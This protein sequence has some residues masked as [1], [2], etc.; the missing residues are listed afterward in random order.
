MIQNFRDKLQGILAMALVCLISIPFVLF[1]VEN[2]FT[3]GGVS[4]GEAAKVNDQ[5]I[6]E[7]ELSRAIS[8][9]KNQLLQ[10]TNGQ[11]PEQFLS[12]E[13]LR[14]PVLEQLIQEALE[15]E[16]AQAS[17]ILIADAAIDKI[18]LEQQAFQQDG[19]FSSQLFR[20]TLA[21]VGYTPSSYRQALQK[22]LS[23]N[24]LRQG[25]LLSGFATATKVE[26]QLLRKAQSRSF[27]FMSIAAKQVEP[28]INLAAGAARQHYD[29]NTAQ[30]MGP[31]RVK[32]EYI[33]LDG[34]KLAS[35]EDIAEA[36]VFDA[37]QQ[38]AGAFQGA[39]RRRIAHILVE[40]SDTGVDQSKVE[41][42]KQ[43]LAS[44][45][46]FAELAQELSDDIVTAEDGGELGFTDGKV[47]DVALESVVAGL[48]VD[49]VSAPL[50]TD[51]GIHFIKLL[52]IDAPKVPSFESKKSEIGTNLLQAKIRKRYNEIY[53][54]LE[55][56]AY[57]AD[58][59]HGLAEQLG[60]EARTSDWVS[61]AGGTGILADASVLER[62]FSDEVLKDR[63]SS[64]VIELPDNRAAVVRVV[65]FEAAK[66]KPFAVVEAQITA[67]LRKQQGAKLLQAKA[68]SLKAKL[69]VGGDVE[70][71]AKA[72]GVDWQVAIDARRNDS[73]VDS[74]TLQQA[75]KLAKPAADKPEFK[76]AAKPNGDYV[77]IQLNRVT[78][79]VAADLLDSQKVTAS[80]SL[81]MQAA[82][83]Q[84]QSYQAQLKVAAEISR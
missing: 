39:E 45:G 22:E 60:I 34:A 26:Q 17:N 10:Q 56:L 67:T 33:D 71:V 75:F 58:D 57:N 4:Q 63:N 53:S 5:V 50:T 47:F 16:E 64:G 51:E 69:Q 55:D 74:F 9:R 23:V 35:P 24:Q 84:F 27:Y 72:G 40:K 37:Y 21:Q 13:R 52:E 1:G 76:I 61:R 41:M 59:L 73:R 66:P 8:S 15:S 77:L 44:G 81:A 11:I 46:D 65:E 3:G 36:D 80:Q 82:G 42:I 19:K 43:R 68:E 25:I 7:L 18:L 49:Q 54:E 79:K 48:V 78:D 2:L 28:D 6:T 32:L 31:E 20:A 29:D 14:G 62:A 30:Y 38:Y 12:D 70:A 83:S